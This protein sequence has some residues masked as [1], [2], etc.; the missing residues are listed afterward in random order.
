MQDLAEASSSFRR[1]FTRYIKAS[2][3]KAIAGMEAAETLHE[4]KKEAQERAKRQ[5]GTRKIVARGEVL[6]AGEAAEC[7]R[8]R[9]LE[10][11]CHARYQSL[12][13]GKRGK[14]RQSFRHKLDFIAELDNSHRLA[15]HLERAISI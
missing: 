5:T 12:L 7:I 11:V 3:A 10:E 9:R 2:H 4:Y 1:Q 13:K 14:V 15:P 8:C 6:K